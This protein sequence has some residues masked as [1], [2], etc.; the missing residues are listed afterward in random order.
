M[1]APVVFVADVIAELNLR[2]GIAVAACVLRDDSVRR[3]PAPCAFA[4][5][6]NGPTPGGRRKSGDEKESEDDDVG[7]HGDVQ[8][9]QPDV[10]EALYVG[11][12]DSG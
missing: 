2:Q 12:S 11:R 3:R 10:W 5:R 9:Q 1:R 4:A 6:D 7:G 8:Q